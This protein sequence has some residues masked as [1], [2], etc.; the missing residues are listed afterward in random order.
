MQLPF[1]VTEFFSVFQDYNEAVWPAQ[2]VLLGLGLA[3]VV[4]VL[5]PRARTGVAIA[6][7]LAFLWGWLALAYHV[8]FFTRINPLAWLFA[9]VSLAG[10]LVFVW[11]GLVRRRLSFAWVGGVRALAGSAL[12]VF[13]LVV[14]PLWSWLAGHPYPATPTFG[15]PCPTTIFTIGLLAFLVVPYPRSVFIVPLL[16]C[17]IGAQAAI[18]LGLP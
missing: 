13:A 15:L 10:A 3:A 9:G 17:F 8:A 1:T 12:I 5:K 14:Y 7:I 4:L 11:H 6:L 2:M 16:W 18:L